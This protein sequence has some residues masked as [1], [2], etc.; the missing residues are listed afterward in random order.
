MQ[1]SMA[2]RIDSFIVHR[3][4]YMYYAVPGMMIVMLYYYAGTGEV[5]IVSIV[6]LWLTTTSSPV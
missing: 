5:M 2:L 4:T 6:L 3:I 1:L